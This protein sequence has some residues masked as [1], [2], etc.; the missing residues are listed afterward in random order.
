MTLNE[1]L[2]F[3]SIKTIRRIFFFLILKRQG[4]DQV[5]KTA[6]FTWQQWKS[7]KTR[8]TVMHFPGM[9]NGVGL[10]CSPHS[11]AIAHIDCRNSKISSAF[12]RVVKMIN[13]PI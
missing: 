5:I 12:E 11:P 6:Q 10:L 4:Q 2:T 1:F 7:K 8:F 9:G 13:K 3:L